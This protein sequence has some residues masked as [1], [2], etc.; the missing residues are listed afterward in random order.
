MQWI[1][2]GSPGRRGNSF[3]VVLPFLILLLIILFVFTTGYI[4][5]PL[6]V[7]FTPLSSPPTFL[8]PTFPLC[9]GKRSGIVICF[10]TVFCNRF[11]NH[12]RLYSPTIRY[13]LYTNQWFFQ[14]LLQIGGKVP[15]PIHL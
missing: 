10:D 5:H 12:L 2:T 13:F 14:S 9:K 1:G 4:F 7:G 6:F 15:N 8:T 11:G 3:V